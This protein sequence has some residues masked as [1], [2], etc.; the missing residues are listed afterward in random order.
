MR[1]SALALL[2][3]LFMVA[4]P[5]AAQTAEAPSSSFEARCVAGEVGVCSDAGLAYLHSDPTRS[6]ALFERGCNSGNSTSCLGLGLALISGPE[7]QRDPARAAPLL[8]TACTDGAGSACGAL[9]NL[10]YLGIGV[11]ED[12]LRAFQ[13]SERGC[14]LRDGRSCAAYGLH[15]STGESVQRDLGRAGAALVLACN[16]R[17]P[18]AC[19]ILENVAAQVARNEDDAAPTGASAV[20]LFEVAC[21]GGQPRSCGV[22]GAFLREGIFGPADLQRAAAFSARGC[23]LDHAMSCADLA[24]AYRRGRGVTRDDTQARA[25]AERAL[26]IDP[27]NEDATR[28]LRRLR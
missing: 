2:A 3:A 22:L 18:R 17:A 20:P 12:R 6:R 25:F 16:E 28:T 24:E 4:L 10:T 7:E 8:E 23:E 19:E 9:S 5:C 14:V 11:P 13:L 1:P 26:S 21:E 27:Q 15:L